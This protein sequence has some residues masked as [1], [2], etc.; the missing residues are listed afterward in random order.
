[1]PIEKLIFHF[2]NHM[3]V[4]ETE[5]EQCFPLN[6]SLLG[7]KMFKTNANTE[8]TFP[9][10][11]GRYPKIEFKIPISFRELA[12]LNIRKLPGLPHV[13]VRFQSPRVF[14]HKILNRKK[15]KRSQLVLSLLPRTFLRIHLQSVLAGTFVV[16]EINILLV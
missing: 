16:P 1:M 9:R 13:K 4:F 3:R 7:K 6:G 15:P 8:N 5:K 2:E 11:Q 12:L 10:L 14:P